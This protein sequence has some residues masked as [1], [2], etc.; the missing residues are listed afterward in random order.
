MNSFTMQKR[1]IG[2]ILLC[3]LLMLQLAV[4]STFSQT[5]INDGPGGPILV[6]SS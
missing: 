5:T 4:Q 3:T 6:I 1:S 2:K